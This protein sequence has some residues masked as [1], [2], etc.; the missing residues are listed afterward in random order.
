MPKR[1][2]PKLNKDKFVAWKILM[3]LHLG[4]IGDHAQTTIIVEHVDPASVPTTEDMKKKK[5]HNQAMLEIAS[6]LS[7]AEF[8]DIKRCRSI[9]QMWEALSNIYGG[10]QNFQRDKRESL[11]GKFD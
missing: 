1:D 4:S 9:F 5:E 2:V 8:D 10:D 7:Y 11:R 6:A 3:K